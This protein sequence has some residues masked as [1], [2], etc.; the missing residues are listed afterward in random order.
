MLVLL[1]SHIMKQKITVS[2][3]TE[4]VAFLDR[5]AHGNRSDYLNSLLA[6]QRKQQL[7]AELIAALKEDAQD[8]EYRNP[9][10]SSSAATSRHTTA[11]TRGAI[12]VPKN[13]RL[14]F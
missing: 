11:E 3:D 5:Q 8:R 10:C 1:S 9:S 4:L 7:E 12:A 2:L 6:Q 14:I 13:F